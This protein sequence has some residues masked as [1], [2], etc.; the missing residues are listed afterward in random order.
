MRVASVL[1]AMAIWLFTGTCAL[2]GE[3]SYSGENH[4][5]YS[6]LAALKQCY[7]PVLQGL[8]G[9]VLTE[10]ERRVLQED[11]FSEA[12]LDKPIKVFNWALLL[13]TTLSL[14][15]EKS[16]DLLEMYVYG[17]ASGDVMRREDAAGGLVKLLTLK[18]IKG[19]STSAELEPSRVLSDLGDVSD[20]QR[21]LVQ[22]AFCE[23]I[24][25]ATVKNLFRPK[26]ALTNAEAVSILSRVIKKYGIDLNETGRV[27]ETAVSA[28]GHWA[29]DMLK[30]SVARADNR[31]G[32]LKKLDKVLYPGETQVC[33]DGPI[34]IKNW[35]GLLLETLELPN[36]KYDRNF[37][38]GYTF[39]LSDGGYITRGSAVAGMV[40][41]LHAA[42]L[43][44]WRDATEKERAES[45]LAFGDYGEARDGSKLAIA[46]SEGLVAGYGD[47][48]FRPGQ[49]ITCAEALALAIRIV[50]KYY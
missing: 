15:D 21:V 31:A 10:E 4:W 30:K 22:V 13:R 23:G 40:K 16:G 42:G 11:I 33:L 9:S 49:K 44:Q 41:L 43:V 1:V 18:Y 36:E 6:D 19:G 39:G 45:A 29:Q 25:D 48:T 14:P 37:L 46:Y 2:A 8:A 7:V 27:G 12:N 26:D 3:S 28:G 17:L 47:G 32:R 24:L 5:A 50:E 20:R 34:G 35:N 38:E